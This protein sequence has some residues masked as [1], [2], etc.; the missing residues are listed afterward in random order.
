MLGYRRPTRDYDNMQGKSLLY[1][2]RTYSC[3]HSRKSTLCC[4]RGPMPRGEIGNSIM[5]PGW[6][7]GKLELQSPQQRKDKCPAHWPRFSLCYFSLRFPMHAYAHKTA[8]RML[9]PPDAVFPTAGAVLAGPEREKGDPV[10]IISDTDGTLTLSV[11]GRRGTVMRH[12]APITIPVTVSF[13][14]QSTFDPEARES[15]TELFGTGDFRIFVGS[16]G[17][18]PDHPDSQF[19]AYEGF[20]FR[21]FPHLADSPERRKTGNESHTAT[22]LWIRNIDPQRRTNSEGKPHTGLLSDACQNRQRDKGRHNCGWSRVLLAPGG[23]GLK[24]GESTEI[25]IAITNDSVEIKA[26]VRCFAYSLKPS[27][28]RVSEIDTIAIGHTNISRGY[29]MLTISGL[30]TNSIAK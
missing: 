21:I 4:R 27:F 5:R 12:F 26:G 13:R 24:N 1:W 8:T 15:P 22:S 2:H 28:S 10:R 14:F 25:S 30:S 7:S 9:P 11:H 18:L 20:Q 23:F 16:K 19:A 17:T 29:K 3:L 6:L